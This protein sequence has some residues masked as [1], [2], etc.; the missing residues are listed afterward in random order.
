MKKL[1]RDGYQKSSGEDFD[2]LQLI[3]GSGVLQS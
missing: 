3:G 1:P 2:F